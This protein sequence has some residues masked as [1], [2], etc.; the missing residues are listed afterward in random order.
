MSELS[1]TSNSPDASTITI[2]DVGGSR[3]HD[4]ESFA[5]SHPEFNGRLVLQDLPETI[6][7]LNG[8]KHVFEAMPYDFFTPQPIKGARLYLLLACL[9]NWD[10]EKSCEILKNLA[11]AMQKG[12]S[13]LLVSG[14]VLPEVKAERRAAELDIQMWVLQHARHRT[15]SDWLQLVDSA[16]LQLVKIWDNG[17]RESL[18]E[19]CV[20]E[21]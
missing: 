8:E 17:D 20:P 16:G 5:E 9:H 12:Y 21:Q 19:M 6:G 4:L 15:R 11:A 18:I 1:A 7:P 10:D 14:V 13:R 2:V 3:G